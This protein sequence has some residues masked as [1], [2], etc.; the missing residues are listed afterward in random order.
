MYHYRLRAILYH[1]EE[2][3]WVQRIALGDT[4]A[5]VSLAPGKA[6]TLWFDIP[7]KTYH[8]SKAQLTITGLQGAEAVLADVCLY[9]YEDFGSQ[10]GGDG[11]GQSAGLGKLK[12]IPV[13]LP[14][15]PNPFARTT[16]ISY[17][18]SISTPVSLR[19]YD[20]SGRSVRVLE[21]PET[22]PQS[23]GRHT[24]R[25]DGRDDLGRMLPSGV[26]FC[27]FDTK[28]CR[29]TQKLVLDQ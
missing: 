2:G 12:L 19:L 18:L 20:L 27:R 28:G 4:I 24:V 23:A 9:Q 17:D 8:D 14:G 11:G 25:W 10:G 1:E 29:A 13:L 3:D 7:Q 22:G 5:T 26:Y 15:Q 16:Q 6:E 21:R